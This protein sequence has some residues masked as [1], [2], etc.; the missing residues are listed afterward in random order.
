MRTLLAVVLL[1]LVGVAE[2]LAQPPS[3]H[4]TTGLNTEL[5]NQ[6]TANPAAQAPGP[7]MITG[8][9]RADMF[10][11]LTRLAFE[12]YDKT[13]ESNWRLRLAVW[14]AFGLATS[15]VLSAA[16]WRPRRSEC[17]LA[18]LIALGVIVTVNFIW[19]P[20]QYERV[21]RWH[22]VAHYWQSAVEESLQARLPDNLHP[23][24][25]GM[26]GWLRYNEERLAVQPRL[27]WYKSP[28]YLSS[29]VITSLFGLLFIAAIL[30]RTHWWHGPKNSAR[31]RAEPGRA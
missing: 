13:T 24:A 31:K 25:L 22:R 7:A 14:A 16:K 10:L 18:S 6:G 1:L 30:G 2:V 3:G 8:K 12:R 27:P 17:I 11:A 26:G 20:Y 29:S 4:R 15:F 21:S 23:A 28:V 9:E 5:T 19:G